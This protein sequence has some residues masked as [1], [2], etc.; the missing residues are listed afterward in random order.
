MSSTHCF[1]RIENRSMELKGAEFLISHTFELK[2]YISIARIG[3]IIIYTLGPFSQKRSH[4][5][6]T[7]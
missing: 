3:N 2:R 6:G 5:Y 7:V 4:K 1:L